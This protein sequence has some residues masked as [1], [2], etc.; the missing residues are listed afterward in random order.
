[1]FKGDDMTITGHDFAVRQMEDGKENFYV[2][3]YNRINGNN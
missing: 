3:R 1:M 2:E